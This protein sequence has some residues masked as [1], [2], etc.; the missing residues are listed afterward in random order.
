MTVLLE[1]NY[2]LDKILVLFSTLVKTT[3][4]TFPVLLGR[5]GNFRVKYLCTPL[6]VTV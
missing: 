5:N 6:T 3:L 4:K 2:T 1:L